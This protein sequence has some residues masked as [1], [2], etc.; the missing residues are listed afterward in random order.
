MEAVQSLR[1]ACAA[2]RCARRWVMEKPA[3]PS[4]WDRITRTCLGEGAGEGLWGQRA[5]GGGAGRG[6]P[7]QGWHAV[8]GAQAAARGHHVEAV[9]AVALYV[10]VRLGVPI[11]HNHDEP[12]PA[13]CQVVAGHALAALGAGSAGVGGRAVVQLSESASSVQLPELVALSRPEAQQRAAPLS[14]S[15]ALS[16]WCQ[17]KAACPG[18]HTCSCNLQGSTKHWQ[19]NTRDAMTTFW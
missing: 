8:L 14:S 2:L 4:S 7:V 12:R 16:K 19:G 6:A 11:L 17:P 13:V 3:F 1:K 9:G 5:A 18:K 15:H 10:Q